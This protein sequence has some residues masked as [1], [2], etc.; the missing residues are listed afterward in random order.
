MVRGWS[1]MRRSRNV[2]DVFRGL[3]GALSRDKRLKRR[4]GD[5]PQFEQVVWDVL[6][7]RCDEYFGKGVLSE[8][9]LCSHKSL[10]L[11]RWS[12]KAWERFLATDGP[13]VEVFGGG[14]RLDMVA[15]VPGTR[16]VGIEVECFSGKR[17]RD[18][19]HC[20]ARAV[21]PGPGE[22]R[23]RDSGRELS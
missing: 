13:N 18:Q 6:L 5:E 9:L 3:A 1:A 15:L 14:R 20:G 16:G 4:F 19:T 7:E 12:A 2:R 10:R 21:S 23:L 22:A 11:S 8:N 17:S